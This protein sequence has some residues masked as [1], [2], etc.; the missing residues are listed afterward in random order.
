MSV[1]GT[2]PFV[3]EDSTKIEWTSLLICTTSS[4]SYSKVGSGSSMGC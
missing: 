3:F 4:D 1:L 2:S